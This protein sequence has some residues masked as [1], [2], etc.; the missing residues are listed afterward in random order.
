MEQ[1]GGW[2]RPVELLFPFYRG[3]SEAQGGSDF[4][5]LIQQSPDSNS[6]C[7]FSLFCLWALVSSVKWE[8][9]YP[10]L[11]L[12]WGMG[13]VYTMSD[14]ADC[15]SSCC[16]YGRG[17]QAPAPPRSW[18]DQV[19]SAEGLHLNWGLGAGSWIDPSF[20]PYP[21][22]P[23]NVPCC[24]CSILYTNEEKKSTSI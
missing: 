4:S 19:E 8:K 20:F 13:T 3:G 21:F 17:A 22:H 11:E 14:Q 5:A 23:N 15:C 16:Y 24:I 10:P 9:S 18:A 1:S 6:G 2:G 7:A 12:W